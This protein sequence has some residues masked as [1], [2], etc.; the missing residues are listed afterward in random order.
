MRDY[1]VQ[2]YD[3]YH[4]CW[5]DMDSFITWNSAQCYIKNEKI[6]DDDEGVYFKYRILKVVEI[7]A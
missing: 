4:Q 6:I 2:F 7:Y 3:E 1:V 5:V